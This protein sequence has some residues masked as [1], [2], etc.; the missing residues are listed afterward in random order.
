MTC[1]QYRIHG[2]VQGVW[3]RESTRREAVGLGISGY[4]RNMPDGSVEVLACGSSEVLDRLEA[5]LQQGPP[6]ARVERVQSEP[7]EA[8]CPDA[9]FTR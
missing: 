7:V 5:W 3:F 8:E 9:F 2:K 4:A 6:M 1:R